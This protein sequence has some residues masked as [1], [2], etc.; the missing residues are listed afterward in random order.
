MAEIL[1]LRSWNK[2]RVLPE[3][4]KEKL[5]PAFEGENLN[6]NVFANQIAV[7]ATTILLLGT[8]L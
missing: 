4:W 5:A 3:N 8:M 6:R 2:F 1:W 7:G